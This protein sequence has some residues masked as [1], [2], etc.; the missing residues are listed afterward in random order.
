MV[1]DF[2]AGTCDISVLEIVQDYKG[3]F[4][5]NIAISRFT[6]LGGDDV[7]RYLTYHYIM[8]RFL[9]ANKK[10]KKDF[11]K[12]ERDIIA[13]KL[14]KVAER[15]KVLISKDLALKMSDYKV[16]NDKDSDKKT[17]IQTNVTIHTS[18]CE[19][20]ASDFYLTN[21]EFT[22]A[23]Q[24]FVKQGKIKTTRC[25]KE[26]YN[27]IFTPIESAISKSHCRKD[28]IDY[29]LLIGG[30]SQNPFIIEALHNYFDESD[31]LVPQNLQTHV[32][33]GAAIHSLLI[34]GF[35]KCLI[36]PITSE[37][38]ILITKDEKPK[39][40][41]KAGTQIPCSDVTISDL[42]PNRD[43]QDKIELNWIAYMCWKR[44]KDV[45]QFNHWISG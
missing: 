24:V 4:S 44:R 30:S 25:D 15:L 10:S 31:L 8:P 29:V 34:N 35:D 28:E 2:G 3:F 6:K 26:E 11:R 38:I 33:Q 20:S 42:T 37:P 22:E 1:F 9:E 7:D 27:S 13:S 40:L 32:S 19:L 45:V 16:S 21:E 5:K 23:M 43:R 18:K 17:T 36:K 14:Y 12:N 41:L 39:V